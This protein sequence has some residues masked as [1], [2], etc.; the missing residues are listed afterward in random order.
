MIQRFK[1]EKRIKK[2]KQKWV[3][4]LFKRNLTN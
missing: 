1:E 3:E 2:H 4:S